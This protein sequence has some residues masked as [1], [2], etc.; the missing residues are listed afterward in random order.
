MR[1]VATGE[2]WAIKQI[3]L[4]DLS[5]QEQADAMREAKILEILRH[6]NIVRFKEVYSTA[7]GKLNIVMEYAE[8]GDLAQRIKAAKKNGM[9]F[10]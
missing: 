3:N 8:G 9:Q 5:P 1:E 4:A 2:Q 10:S 6:P 7:K